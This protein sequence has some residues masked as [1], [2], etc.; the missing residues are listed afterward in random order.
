MGKIFSMLFVFILSLTLVNCDHCGPD[1]G[2]ENPVPVL[3][4]ISPVSKVSHMPSF[5]LTASGS[6][7]VSDSTIVFDGVEKPTTFVSDTEISCE[8]DPGDILVSLIQTREGGYNSSAA[9]GIVPVLVRNPSP[10]GGDSGS[11]N[12]TIHDNHTFIAPVR[13]SISPNSHDPDIAADNRGNVNVVWGYSFFTETDNY[14]QL[15]FTRSTN[16][17]TSWIPLVV[18]ADTSQLWSS[19][20]SIG[21]DNAGNIDVVWEVETFDH[22]IYFCQST[23]SGTSWN[24]AVQITQWTDA[25]YSPVIGVSG[26]GNI[27]VAWIMVTT[28]NNYNIFF[29][30]SV[31]NGAS[32]STWENVSNSSLSSFSPDI[33][34]DSAE[35]LNVVWEGRDDLS[36]GEIFFSRS[37]NDGVSWSPPVNLSNTLSGGSYNPAIAVDNTGNINVVWRDDIPVPGIYFK[38]SVDS[39]VSW[40]F[41]VKISDLSGSPP[42]ITGFPAIAIDSAGNINVG[43]QDIV[44]ANSDIF[45]SRSTD[46]GANW[47]APINISTSADDISTPGFGGPKITVDP[48]GN[49]YFVWESADRNIYFSTNTR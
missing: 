22:M 19:K 12:F 28:T 47:S 30:R 23:D 5:T 34:V 36:N 48:P 33:A 1:N 32:W 16:G 35:N 15:V 11:L 29:T 40:S 18:A 39:G 26:P 42:A 37:I 20:P 14:E 4:S 43:W 6:D 17:G 38:R 10:G 45:F 49:I 21:V 25:C 31:N 3:N 13:L 27:N 24:P 7:F 9:S 8:I 41:S 46:N 44:T 2:E